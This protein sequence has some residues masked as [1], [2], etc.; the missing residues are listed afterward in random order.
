MTDVDSTSSRKDRMVIADDVQHLF[1][2]S[3]AKNVIEDAIKV[4]EF[5]NNI[6]NTI[7][8]KSTDAFDFLLKGISDND[9]LVFSG[10]SQVQDET[11]NQNL[12]R[13]L[14]SM[15]LEIDPVSGDGD[16]AFSSIIRQLYKLPEFM[17]EGILTRHLHDM[18]LN[19]D[20]KTDAFTLRQRFVDHVQANE[21]YQLLTGI[22]ADKLSEETELFR[23]KE[24][25]DFGQTESES[26]ICSRGK[27]NKKRGSQASCQ[28]HKDKKSN[29]PCVKENVCCSRKCKCRNCHNLF[30]STALSPPTKFLRCRCGETTAHRKDSGIRIV[31]CRDTE[32]KSK[33]PCLGS[34]QGCSD[35]CRCFNRENVNGT[36]L[37]A[38]FN[39]PRGVKKKEK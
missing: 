12:K 5:L 33:C 28:Q 8:D 9:K 10:E 34:Y 18:G 26:T 20:E 32:K 2:D 22:S 15:G 1:D 35:L 23:E 21:H 27:N 38:Q 3:I 17:N 13:N 39:S 36:R 6:N 14:S 4:H 30:K 31:S 24:K 7:N 29:C 11:H 16:C 37:A 25:S 19:I